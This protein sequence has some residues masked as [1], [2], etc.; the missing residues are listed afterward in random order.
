[1]RPPGRESRIDV[2]LLD[3]SPQSM[4]E[5]NKERRELVP[6]LQQE[7]RG[8]RIED[9]VRKSGSVPFRQLVCDLR[10]ARR[11]PLT[12]GAGGLASRQP[13]WRV[14]LC[15][16]KARISSVG[17]DDGRPR[18]DPS[19]SLRSGRSCERRRNLLKGLCVDCNSS[20]CMQDQVVACEIRWEMS[21]CTRRPPVVAETIAGKQAKQGNRDRCS[22]DRRE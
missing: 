9:I 6:W 15:V 11:I 16:R 4:I 14:R 21:L 2:S 1:M 8:Q 5:P 22:E 10:T 17:N 13:S 3:L 18:E 12:E 19:S 7:D 20:L